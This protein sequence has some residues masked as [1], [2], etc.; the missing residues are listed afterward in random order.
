M[1]STKRMLLTSVILGS[2]L[3]SSILQADTLNRF[4]QQRYE[5]G[6]RIEKLL[7]EKYPKL[8]KR[9]GN[10]LVLR[11]ANRQKA[12]YVDDE[13]GYWNRYTLIDYLEDIDAFLL[14]WHGFVDNGSYELLLRKNG[15][16][17]AGICEVPIF[18]TNKSKFVAISKDLEFYHTNQI[19]I[20]S[21][22]NGLEYQFGSK[23]WGPVGAEWLSDDKISITKKTGPTVGGAKEET[24]LLNYRN[25]TWRLQ[26]HE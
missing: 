7:I 12:E 14:R 25:Q 23:E 13:D 8:I 26:D 21:I 22:E 19:Q 6:Q 2:C 3:V 10:R 9:S 18:S 16:A 1:L 17:I 15:K 24:V 4:F 5:Y 20:F 11:L